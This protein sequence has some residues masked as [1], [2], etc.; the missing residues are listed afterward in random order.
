M[1]N[2]HSLLTVFDLSLIDQSHMNPNLTPFEECFWTL[3][4]LKKLKRDFNYDVKY[5]FFCAVSPAF[6]DL[7]NDPV[8]NE[9]IREIAQNFLNTLENNVTELGETNNY[10][11]SDRII[12]QSSER[13]TYREIRLKF[14]DH[15]IKRL[16][17]I[18]QKDVA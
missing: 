7:W 12:F 15:E 8:G 17:A 11:L 16:T 4:F 18:M 9:R 6:Y 5:S 13:Y 14:L 10:Q 2:S 3:D 1:N